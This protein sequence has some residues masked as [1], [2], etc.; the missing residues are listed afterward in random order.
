[1]NL[2]L[3][4]IATR[5]KFDLSYADEDIH[6]N[7]TIITIPPSLVKLVITNSFAMSMMVDQI[8][9]VEFQYKASLGGEIVFF[10]CDYV[11]ISSN[12]SNAGLTVVE[13]NNVF[14]GYSCTSAQFYIN[15]SSDVFGVVTSTSGKIVASRTRFNNIMSFKSDNGE[16]DIKDCTSLVLNTTT[17]TGNVHVNRHEGG[18]INSATVSGTTKFS[19][20]T[21]MVSMRVTSDNGGLCGTGTE[22]PLFI[23]KS[24]VNKFQLSKF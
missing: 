5:S 15:D 13:C 2:N 14:L 6:F 24:G 3:K 10:K 7:E 22:M 20:N 8:R 4:Q 17:R 9:N 23:T 21:K 16:M 11:K 12:I 18:A 19:N 1:M